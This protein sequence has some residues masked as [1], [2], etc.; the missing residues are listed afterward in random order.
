MRSANRNGS[1]NAPARPQDD[2]DCMRTLALTDR[3][4]VNPDLAETMIF[5]RRQFGPDLE[6]TIRV[7]R[8][9]AR[10][11]RA[12]QGQAAYSAPYNQP[13]GNP[14]YVGA[15]GNPGGNGG[16]GSP[17]AEP[18]ADFAP[19]RRPVGR[20]VLLAAGGLTLLGGIGI[21]AARSVHSGG[22]GSSPVAAAPARSAGPTPSGLPSTAGPSAT[23]TQ[24]AT[25]QPT[26]DPSG[27]SGN[28]SGGA[29][30]RA[31]NPA[32]VQTKPEYYVENGPKGIALTLDDGPTAEYTP[33]ILALL[34]QYGIIATFCMIGEQIP[35]NAALVREVAAAGHTIVNHTWD[36]ADQTKLSATQVRDSIARTSEALNDVGVT[37]TVFRAPYGSW[38]STV[39]QACADARMRPLDWS[40]DP[41]DWARPGSSVIV[42][43][44]LK[45]TS[46]G[47]IILE[48]DG[49]GDRSQ[50]VAALTVVLPELLNAGYRFGPI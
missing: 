39:F 17:A 24:S 46:T 36:H 15:G 8:P 9:A 12:G 7:D 34:Q 20:R 2:E 13:Y 16:P 4:R 3:R 35:P 25:Q 33:K 10:D 31:I 32:Q 38:N 48:H 28:P 45:Q 40:V 26:D 29:T 30:N 22:S 11:D 27:A 41:Q 14:V 43:R 5:D 23:P 47:S 49:G 42:Q 18:Y 6:T 44:I 50:T 37:P 1:V 21:A 19:R